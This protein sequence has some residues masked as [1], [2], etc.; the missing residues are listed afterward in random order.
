MRAAYNQFA[1][2]SLD[3]LAALSDGLFAFAVTLLFSICTSLPLRPPERHNAAR[4][5]KTHVNAP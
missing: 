4:W 5:A 3:R 2:Q 1:G